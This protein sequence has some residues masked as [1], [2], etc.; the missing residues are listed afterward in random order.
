MS[1]HPHFQ[2]LADAPIGTHLAR[3]DTRIIDADGWYRL[4]TPSC[5]EASLNGVMRARI[6]AGRV[7]SEVERVLGEYAALGVRHRWV[8]GP[9]SDAPGLERA[10]AAQ[11]LDSWQ[12]W[13]MC[14]PS[15]IAV[16]SGDARVDEVTDL[17]LYARVSA[18]GWGADPAGLF[19]SLQHA[20]PGLR[21]FVA[22][23]DGEPVGSAASFHRESS[24]Y[25]VGAVVHPAARGRGA[26]RA[27]LAARA[28]AAASDG[29]PL[30]VTHAREHTSGPLLLRVGFET[31]Y[32]YRI[33]GE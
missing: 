6:A 10:L 11:G 3:A 24:A 23:S 32:T 5:P 29:V 12:T 1:A 22:Y 4:L 9:D 7:K 15:S 33:F 17:A 27:L 21:C 26:Y 18:R 19:A 25:L 28:R 30:L 13:A 8:A 31:V 20:R 2:T 14:A 16:E